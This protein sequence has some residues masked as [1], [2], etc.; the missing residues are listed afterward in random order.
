MA[1]AETKRAHHHRRHQFVLVHGIC[2]GAWC[3][4]KAVTALRRAG[5]RATA[6]DMAGCGTH[7]ARVDAVRRFEEYSR[8][9][10]DAVAAAP[11][12]ERLVLVGHSLGGLS[13][14]LAM[15]RFP[16]KVAA[17]VFLAA[18]MPRIGSH[19]GITI[20]E[21]IAKIILGNSVLC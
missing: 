19:M 12:G 10:L 16:G 4:Y 1:A 9:L 14:A 15:E 21:V 11:D 3:W 7:P 17:A 2:H 18:S 8:P 20:Q 6:L 5:H 13:V